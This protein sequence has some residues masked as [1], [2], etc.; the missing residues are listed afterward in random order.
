MIKKNF[1]QSIFKSVPKYNFGIISE[2]NERLNKKLTGTH[3][4][5]EKP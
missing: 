3:L 5:L 2:Y 1:I 4:V